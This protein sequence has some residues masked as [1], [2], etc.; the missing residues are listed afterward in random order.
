[1]AIKV[2][3][4]MGSNS[5][6]EVMKDACD[7][8]DQFGI[9]YEKRVVSAHR[10]PDLMYEY[11]HTAKK[12]GI[13]VLIAG[14]GGAAHL[15]GMVAAMTSLPVIGVPVKSRALNGLDSLLSIVQ[16]PGGVPVL[17]VAINGAK[18][19]ALSAIAILATNDEALSKKYE[20]FR[21]NQTDTVLKI[22]L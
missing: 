17:T 8:L 10:T 18:N 22:E 15:P 19:A 6:Y 5:D 2:G 14:A 16:M 7:V 1:M 13:K 20:E 4:I 12:R 11:A 21:Q 3:I 9:E